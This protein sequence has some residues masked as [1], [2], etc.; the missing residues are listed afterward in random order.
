MAK[1]VEPDD[2]QFEKRDMQYDVLQPQEDQSIPARKYCT[3]DIEMC[4]TSRSNEFMTFDDSLERLKRNGYSRHLRV[5]EWLEIFEDHSAIANDVYFDGDNALKESTRNWGEWVSLALEF[6]GDALIAYID[7][8]GLVWNPRKEEYDQ[9]NFS[10][11]SRKEFSDFKFIEGS[12]SNLLSYKDM[13]MEFAE[14]VYGRGMIE[15]YLQEQ[16]A[17]SFPRAGMVCPIIRGNWA[18][19]HQLFSSFPQGKSRGVREVK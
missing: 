18:E 9:K 17:V 19:P 3:L 2:V 4:G 16:K 1:L 10:Y 8:V 11:V 15:P 7:P 14:F 12:K 13:P 5:S 6:T